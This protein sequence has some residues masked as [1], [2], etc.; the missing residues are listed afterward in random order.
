MKIRGVDFV[1]YNIT[2]MKRSVA[3]YRDILGLP[4]IGAV[5]E[6]WTEFDTGT[7]ALSVGLWGA[8]PLEKG[9]KGNASVALSVDDVAKAVAELKEKG[10]QVNLEAQDFNA[11]GMASISDPDGNEIVLHR[12]KD[13]TVG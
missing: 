7:V 8:K 11:C 4:V 5:G 10:V 13:G 1:F 2:D 3:F 12:R 6:Q 9:Q